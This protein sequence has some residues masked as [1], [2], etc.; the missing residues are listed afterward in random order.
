MELE[1]V[2]IEIPGVF[3]RNDFL[4]FHC[5]LSKYFTNQFSININSLSVEDWKAPALETTDLKLFK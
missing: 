3:D 1:P 4:G 2:Q 5:S